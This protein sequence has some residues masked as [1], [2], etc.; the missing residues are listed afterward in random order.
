MPLSENL[1]GKIARARDMLHASALPF[2]KKEQLHDILCSAAASANGSPDKIQSMS[3][4][5]LLSVILSIEDRIQADHVLTTAIKTAEDRHDEACLFKN[6][7]YGRAVGLVVLIKWPMAVVL[8]VA[9][10]TN[11]VDKII[12]AFARLM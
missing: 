1:V 2:E 11:N 8:C 12:G 6:S 3:E 9:M 7:N 4:T 10:V 5:L